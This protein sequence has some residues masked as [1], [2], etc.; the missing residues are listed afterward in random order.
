MSALEAALAHPG[1]AGSIEQLVVDLARV[2]TEEAESSMQRAVLHV[3]LEMQG[4]ASS[5]RADAEK[6]T[7]SL[8]AERSASAA[9]RTELV[10]ARASIEQEKRDAAALRTEAANAS[11]AL[12]QQK[13]AFGVELTKVR[14]ALEQEQRASAGLRE[15]VEKAKK[16][17]QQEQQASAALR[18]EIE[19]ARAAIEKERQAAKA[20]RD[21]A[22]KTK[23]T[24][25]DE[26]R[27]SGALRTEL[28]DAKAGLEKQQRTAEALRESLE[29]ARAAA[30]TQ[31]A[32]A[33][34]RGRDL[35]DLRASLESER[36]RADV[37]ERERGEMERRA[38]EAI[39]RVKELEARAAETEKRAQE[40][41]A[42][43]TKA[44]RGREDLSGELKAARLE[45]DALTTELERL[46]AQIA[47]ASQAADKRFNDL[48]EAAAE[49]IRA[50]ELDLLQRDITTAE[51]GDIDLASSFELTE[52]AGRAR[53]ARPVAAD[54][55]VPDQST[56]PANA[57]FPGPPRR[58]SR[59]AFAHEVGVQIDGGEATLV[60]LSV[61]GAQV[62]SLTALKPN[63]V[64]KLQLPNDNGP[65]SCKGKIVWA[66]LEPPSNGQPFRYRAGIFFVTADP[67]GINTFMARHAAVGSHVT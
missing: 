54:A 56:A 33:G 48:S 13:Q 41:A 63:R 53:R 3:Q 5:A 51:P 62:I 32:T 27:I 18:K 43:A 65:M 12:E 61:T 64:V 2:A 34:A 49:R 11:A 67:A 17:L 23:S 14:T 59:H 21:A 9:L 57:A 35:N 66:R 8:E 50:L 16:D 6:A 22:E 25:E 4:Q 30:A 39:A 29:A 26:R 10:N 1:K 36:A 60:D 20:V 7:A 37:L 47:V 52:A 31:E 24:L 40:T 58:A 45:R 19:E 38:R 15:A 55:A 46:R 28:A 44:A 42:L